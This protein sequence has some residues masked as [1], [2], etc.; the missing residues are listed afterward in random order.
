MK[1]RE[2]VSNRVVAWSVALCVLAGRPVS[3]LAQNPSGVKERLAD[4][5]VTI[6]PLY[7]AALSEL[8]NGREQ[9]GTY[10]GNLNVQ[11][12]L[13]G[14]RLFGRSGLTLFVDGL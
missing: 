1:S 12:S 14:D 4:R 9:K 2:Q 7:G 5:G 8:N 13:D 11:V 3:V 10:S 6:T